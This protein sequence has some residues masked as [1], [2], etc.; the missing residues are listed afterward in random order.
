MID[1]FLKITDRIQRRTEGR[2]RIRVR[3]VPG[4]EEIVGNEEV[5]KEAKEAAKG[6]KSGEEEL[7]TILRKRLPISKSATKQKFDTT[8]KERAFDRYKT[9]AQYERIRHVDE[10]FTANSYK[11]LTDDLTRRQT[12]LLVGLRTGHVALN[13]HLHRIQ[14]AESAICEGCKTNE[15]TVQHFF[16]RCRKTERHRRELQKAVGMRKAGDLKYLLSNKEALK[17]L[18]QY[19]HATGRFTGAFGD[20]RIEDKSKDKGK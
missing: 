11:K 8:L 10:D 6:R 20:V 9:S 7:P 12:S 3:W 4:H 14:K 19:I 13:K 1:E 16:L 15:E 2:R 5:D 17:P 18:F